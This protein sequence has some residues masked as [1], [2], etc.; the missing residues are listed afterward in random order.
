MWE[1]IS[2]KGSGEVAV[3]LRRSALLVNCKEQLLETSL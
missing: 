3:E 1:K 2:N